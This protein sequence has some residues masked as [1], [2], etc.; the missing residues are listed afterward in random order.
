[1]LNNALLLSLLSRVGLF[2]GGHTTKMFTP[3]AV[4]SGFITS[5]PTELGPLDENAAIIGAGSPYIVP[6]KA[7][8]AVA[9]LAEFTYFLTAIPADAPKELAA[10]CEYL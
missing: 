4:T 3:G 6:L 1:M 5:D 8:E 9:L 10:E 7:I 2:I